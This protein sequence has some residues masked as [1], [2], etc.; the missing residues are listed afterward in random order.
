MNLRFRSLLLAASMSAA[1]LSL[2]G[3]E[4]N[5][6][7]GRQI[8]TMGSTVEDDQKIG[9]REHPKIIQEFGGV[10]DD[11]NVT[12]YVAIIGARMAA[13]SELPNIP[14]RFT[15]LNSED[16]NAFALPGG[17]VYITRGL[18]ALAA[19]EAEVA[20][21]LAHEIG[22]V[23]ARHSAERQGDATVAGLSAA[24]AGLLLGEAGGQIASTVGSGYIQHYSQSQEFEADTL[25]VRYLS[26]TGYQIGAMADFLVKMRDYSALQ[27]KIAGRP[28]SAV[29]QADFFASHPRTLDR[30]QKAAAEAGRQ[31]GS[32]TTLNRE[33]YLQTIHGMTFGDDPSQGVIRGRTFIHPKLMFRFEAPD[34]F[35][36]INQPD[37]VLAIGPNNAMAKFDMASAQSGTAADFLR[38]TYGQKASLQNLERIEVNGMEG[39]TATAR[40]RT[41]AGDADIRLIA[42]KSGDNRMY[43]FT[44]ATPTNVTARLAEPLRR[45]TYS[46]RAIS[47]QEAAAIKPWRIQVQRVAAGDTVASLSGRMAMA[48]YK[49]DWFRTLN[50]LKPGDQVQAGQ[51]V[52]IV[53]EAR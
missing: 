5:T 30:V 19:N 31:A 44:F 26:R 28:A 32:G 27:N 20:G 10:Y 6:A 51:M 15:V 11:P 43:Q 8:F 49:E 35:R 36:L 52:K 12:A 45:M 37:A 38:R 18:L 48:D 21:V 7:T 16:L 34:G 41:S 39:A 53:A 40:G 46:L 22:H 9:A 29:D 13:A 2:S 33:T 42:I 4:T 3:C 24:V 17:Y 47:A 14:W 25:G 1:A 23:T 50:G